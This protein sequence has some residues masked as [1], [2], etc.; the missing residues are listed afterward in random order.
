MR[1]EIL[2]KRDAYLVYKLIEHLNGNI[3]YYNKALWYNLDPD[4]RYMLLDGFDI[5]I[6]NDSACRSEAE[7][8]LRW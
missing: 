7:A 6:F 1:R 2:V 4:R 5:Q 8:S 3:E